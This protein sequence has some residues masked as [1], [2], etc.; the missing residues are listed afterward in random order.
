MTFTSYI[1]LVLLTYVFIFL[2]QYDLV[3]NCVSAFAYTNV[4]PNQ[5]ACSY[6]SMISFTTVCMHLL[7]RMSLQIKELVLVE[8]V[9]VL[10]FYCV[11]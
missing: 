3:Y 8:F 6:C 7:I 10:T 5:R 9:F 4:T 1:P 11:V 2:L